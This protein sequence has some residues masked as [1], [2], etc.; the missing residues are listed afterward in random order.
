MK[1]QSAS[2]REFLKMLTLGASAIGVTA[3]FGPDM[4]SRLEGLGRV[5]EP[6]YELRQ[7]DSLV[8]GMAPDRNDLSLLRPACS[9]IV[10]IFED[11][12]ES[13]W[14]RACLKQILEMG[15]L[16]ML[17][18]TP[19]G[20]NGEFLLSK[21][22]MFEDSLVKRAKDFAN[23]PGPVLLRPFYE[24]NGNWFAHGAKINTAEDFVGSWR[25]LV[26]LF[27][28]YAPNVKFVF[29]PNVTVGAAAIAPYY[30]G[31]EWVDI[32]GLDGYNKHRV[33]LIDAEHLLEPRHFNP[34]FSFKQ[35]FGPDFKEL[36]R[37]TKGKKPMIIAEVGTALEN[38]YFW[39][40]EGLESLRNWPVKAAVLFSWRKD[41]PLTKNEANW[42]NPEIF[43]AIEAFSKTTNFVA[44]PT[45]PE[46]IL[47]IIFKSA[48]KN[49]QS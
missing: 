10:N 38:P 46:A 41:E 49:A 29:S 16:P 12:L 22:M 20:F 36:Q 34:N 48:P 6:N 28:H 42:D 21:T 25:Y 45:S 5:G 14:G 15:K 26:G 7:P 9:S 44:S 32:V 8:F 1:E 2:R 35:L 43:Q 18:F 47:E 27:R 3:Q 40:R 13:S 33:N 30:P 31:D 17:S 11:G 23:L 19:Q 37:L 4:L 24:M 39:F